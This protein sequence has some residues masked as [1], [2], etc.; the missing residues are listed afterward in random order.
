VSVGAEGV[1]A[2]GVGAEGVAAADI[3]HNVRRRRAE[4]RVQIVR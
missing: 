3:E 1:A 4:A 2:A